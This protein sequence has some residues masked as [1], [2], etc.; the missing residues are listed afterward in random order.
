MNIKKR[1]PRDRLTDLKKKSIQS[2][3]PF[4]ISQSGSFRG[5]KALL[6]FFLNYISSFDY[7]VNVDYVIGDGQDAHRRHW[8]V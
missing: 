4:I 1:N 5:S 3:F 2:L 6:L 7:K 8:N